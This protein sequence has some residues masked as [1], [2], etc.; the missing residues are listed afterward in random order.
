MRQVLWN[1]VRNGVQ[2]SGAGSTVR[3]SIDEVG[4]GP[5]A[6]VAMAVRD[7][8][9]GI[10]AG[11]HAKIFE[12]FFTTRSQGAWDRARGRPTNHRRPREGRRLDRRTK[13][14]RRSRDETG[15]ATF[16]VG[17]ARAPA[18]GR[19]TATVGLDSA[20]DPVSHRA[21]THGHGPRESEGSRLFET[22]QPGMNH[23]DRVIV[24]PASP[25]SPS[26]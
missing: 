22:A 10:A 2:A 19:R 20:S 26:A 21:L 24:Q 9:P 12:A 17:L 18:P 3:V 13:W 5:S 4:A 7:S 11:S 23:A 8:G 25:S 6:R 16:E 15:G 1:L 14:F